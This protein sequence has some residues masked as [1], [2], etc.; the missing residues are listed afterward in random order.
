[1]TFTLSPQLRAAAPTDVPLILAMVRELAEYELAPTAVATTDAMLREALFGARPA[2]EV[3]LAFD[4]DEA[5][6]FAL[7]FHSFST[8]VGRRGLYLEDLFVRPAFRGLGFG[9][10]LLAHLAGVAV[11]RECG[12]MEWAVL[13]WNKPAIGFY[14]SMG[15]EPMHEWTVF[16]LTGDALAGAAAQ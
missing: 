2:A 1:M 4:G 13:D 12:R 15:A 9:R 6:G 10:A 8:W 16:R 3:I 14:Q 7:F 5:A 11:E